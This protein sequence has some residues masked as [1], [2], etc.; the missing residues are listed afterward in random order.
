MNTFLIISNVL[1]WVLV[2][3]LG[4]TVYALT[5]Q[6][7]ILYERV[8]PAGALMV[9]QALKVND[10]AP[11]VNSVTLDGNSLTLGRP[12]AAGRGQLLFFLA[13]D[14]PICKSLLPI[15]KSMRRSGEDDVDIV[16]ASDGED[17][18][19]H[20]AYVVNQQL[21]DFPYVVSEVLGKSYGVAK[22]PYA[23]LIRGDATI[24]S[25]VSYTHLTLPTI[26][27]V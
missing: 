19:E 20:R 12:L 26:Y 27:S 7:G 8:A 23:V 9:N 24:A 4:M 17:V 25:S 6:I 11:E 15:L 2:I 14:C 21:Q 13:P 10:P 1:L 18:D 16:L 5:R 3:G 22:L